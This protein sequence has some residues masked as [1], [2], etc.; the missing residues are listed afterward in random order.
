MTDDIKKLV[1]EAK[2]RAAAFIE[3]TEKNRSRFDVGDVAAA[4]GMSI[5]CHELIH[6][7]SAVAGERDRMREA[8]TKIQDVWLDGEDGDDVYFN[9]FV[10][11]HEKVCA[12][13]TAALNPEAK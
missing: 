11:C 5:T 3:W 1:E 12:I 4:C 9:G 6:T 13:A 2:A 8:L 10:N 7:L